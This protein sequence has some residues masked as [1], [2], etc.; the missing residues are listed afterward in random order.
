M[1]VSTKTIPSRAALFAP[2]LDENLGMYVSL[3]AV[4]SPAIA[5][6][7][8]SVLNNLTLAGSIRIHPQGGLLADQDACKMFVAAG[9]KAVALQS[10]AHLWVWSKN[11]AKTRGQ[12]ACLLGWAQDDGTVRLYPEVLWR[13]A[14]T[15]QATGSIS[16]FND[17]PWRAHIDTTDAAVTFDRNEAASGKGY[18][19]WWSIGPANPPVTPFFLEPFWRVAH[20]LALVALRNAHCGQGVQVRVGLSRA[21]FEDG[22]YSWS[23]NRLHTRVQ[24]ITPASVENDLVDATSL[25]LT[26]VD[27]FIGHPNTLLRPIHAAGNTN[28][29]A[30]GLRP[31]FHA[32]IG[33]QPSHVLLAALRDEQH[34]ANDPQGLVEDTLR[35]CH[36]L[37]AQEPTSPQ[38]A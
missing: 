31:F 14:S 27:A 9:A 7:T 6:K 12:V 35:A 4:T 24:S 33:S 26:L 1:S 37:H 32:T 19:P 36:A 25:V 5:E 21:A 13:D 15:T 8:R 22:L 38:H 10:G 28:H 29:N 30:R 11:A 18:L 20:N 2:S 17:A 23:N 3:D 16:A 34:F